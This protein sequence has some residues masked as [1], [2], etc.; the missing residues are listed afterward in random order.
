MRRTR[1]RILVLLTA[2]G[3]MAGFAQMFGLTAA[4]AQTIYLNSPVCDT[5]N[6]CL[7]N[8]NGGGYG[9]PVKMYEHL[10]GTNE[11]FQVV[12]VVARCGGYATASCPFTNKSIDAEFVGDPVVEILDTADG[13]CLSTSTGSSP[14]VPDGT[15][16]LGACPLNGQG[17]SPGNIFVYD[18][19][20]T[21]VLLSNY[22]TNSNDSPECIG[23]PSNSNGAYIFLWTGFGDCTEWTS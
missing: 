21:N 5:S 16:L 4:N 14:S 3:L 10:S 13:A 1:S 2:V 8:W 11:D 12:Q 15:A 20:D 9:N 17:G 23:P 7:N 22:W 18:Y 6:Y 19:G